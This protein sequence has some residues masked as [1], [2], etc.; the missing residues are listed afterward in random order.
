MFQRIAGHVKTVS[1]DMA[2]FDSANSSRVDE[3]VIEAML[4]YFREF[5][6]TAG[7][8]LSHA[9]DVGALTGLENARKIIAE[10]LNADSRA[11]V[12]TSGVTESNNI[13]IQGSVKAK[14]GS[15]KHVITSPIETQSVLKTIHSL[16]E[17][18]FE[19][20]TVNV[21][22]T[23]RV[24]LDHLKD[25][26]QKDTF[27]ISIQHANGEIGTIQPIEDIAKI[28]SKNGIIFHTDASQSYLKIPLDT[29][30]IP[31]DLISI[32][33]HRIHGPKGIGVL[34]IKRGTKISN[35]TQGGDEERR[36]RPGIENIPGAVGFAKAVEIWSANEIEHF[37]KLSKHLKEK[38]AENLT[39]YRVTGHPEK[40]LPNIFSIVIEQIEGESILVQ[41]DM[42]GFSVS[43]GSACSSKTLQGSHVLKA[44]GLPPEIS[45]GSVRVS[46]SRY[47]T[48]EEIDELVESLVP[49]VERLR[50]FSP[51]KTGVYFAN[52]DSDEHD[53]HHDLPEDDW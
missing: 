37:E 2:Y 29:K 14:S 39:D 3:R 11:I 28:T 33:A 13:A 9:Q 53:H 23:G 7:L 27:L 40:R 26:I 4:P 43:T 24:D 44:I 8:E 32:D 34:Y 1:S 31:V 16:K 20:D 21:D 45:H 50:E 38:L 41:L 46:F 30:K 12:F 17:F 15:R 36:L 47:N 19:I 10:S 49:A 25:L 5:Y 22:E 6:G 35:I 42:D 51:L 52:D 48:L 18:N